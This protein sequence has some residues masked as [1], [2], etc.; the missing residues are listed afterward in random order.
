[1]GNA[2]RVRAPGS[3]DNVYCVFAVLQRS[4][5]DNLAALRST[6]AEGGDEVA[7]ADDGFEAWLRDRLPERGLRPKSAAVVEVLVSQPRR[8]SFGSTAEL[9][10]LAWAPLAPGTRTAQA[11]GFAGGAAV[12]P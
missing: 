4:L 12:P 1:M 6:R 2:F 11:L 9:A 10:Q 8:A 7:E 3:A 5:Q